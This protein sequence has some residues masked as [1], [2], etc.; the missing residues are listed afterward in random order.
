MEVLR[1]HVPRVIEYRVALRARDEQIRQMPD[2]IRKTEMG[3]SRI[4]GDSPEGAG[5]AGK[6]A[7]ELHGWQHIA[8]P[9]WL[10]IGPDGEHKAGLGQNTWRSRPGELLQPMARWR[11]EQRL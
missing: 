4:G 5:A 2:E 7:G 10:R 9:V 1:P 6:A 8:S 3:T 11:G